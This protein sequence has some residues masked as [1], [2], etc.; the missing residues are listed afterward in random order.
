MRTLRFDV[1]GLPV[2]QG[3]G[4]AVAPGVYKPEH[5]AELES[6]QQAVGWT[7][8]ETVAFSERN[9]V[10][11]TEQPCAVE[12]RFRLPRGKTVTREYPA[13]K[14][15]DLDKLVRAALDGLTHREAKP[16]KPFKPGVLV[17]DGYVVTL[18]ATKRYVEIGEGPGV[19]IVVRELG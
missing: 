9:N 12:L 7:S 18:R 10:W 11:P 15:D 14:R 1:E 2:T 4:V 8:W 5:S 16:R 19:A 17:D 3:S 6:W 13:I